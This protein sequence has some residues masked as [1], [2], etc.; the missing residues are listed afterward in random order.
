M[1]TKLTMLSKTL[2]GQQGAKTCSI[3]AE[4]LAKNQP[5]FLR[6]ISLCNAWIRE[7][8]LKAEA[9]RQEKPIHSQYIYMS[10]AREKERQQAGSDGQSCRSHRRRRIKTNDL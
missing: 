1:V 10:V 9:K 3:N 5:T 4:C 2:N 7:R 8:V 6:L